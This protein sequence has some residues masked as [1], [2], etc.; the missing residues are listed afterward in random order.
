MRKIT[1][2]EL[3]EKATLER[4]KLFS[5]KE[6]EFYDSMDALRVKIMAVIEETESH[7]EYMKVQLEGAKNLIE[8]ANKLKWK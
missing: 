7:M 5:K 8:Q 4:A 3:D 6:R 2:R 1:N